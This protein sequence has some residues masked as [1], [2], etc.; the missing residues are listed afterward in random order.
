[1]FP[2]QWFLFRVQK[3]KI[4]TIRCVKKIKISTFSA[5]RV[6]LSVARC[7]YFL[8]LHVLIFVFCTWYKSYW[9]G[10]VHIPPFN[11]ESK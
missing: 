7:T 3:T 1:M 11:V 6:L 8:L 9:G 4:S 10:N 5:K 2:P